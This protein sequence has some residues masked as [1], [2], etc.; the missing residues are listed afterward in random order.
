MVAT[1]SLDKTIALWDELLYHC[2]FFTTAA[3]VN[4][5]EQIMCYLCWSSQYQRLISGCQSGRII[6]WKI[7][8]SDNVELVKENVF[9]E[10]SYCI[11]MK[12]QQEKK[13]GKNEEDRSRNNTMNRNSTA[14]SSLSSS[15]RSENDIS[16]KNKSFGSLLKDYM[17]SNSNKS[18]EVKETSI[19]Q[20][21]QNKKSLLTSVLPSSETRAKVFF[22]YV[23]IIV[24]ILFFYC[25][26]MF[27]AK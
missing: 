18:L 24:M 23:V 11:R 3:R 25:F 2:I 13:E 17:L 12:N 27:Y 16:F 21:P 10:L 26:Y 5:G 6:V 7:I 15:L 1:V 22:F 20:H 9:Y 14:Y 4:E 19:Q 8:T